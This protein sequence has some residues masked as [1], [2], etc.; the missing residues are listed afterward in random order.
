MSVGARIL[1]KLGGTEWL[2]VQIIGAVWTIFTLYEL[3][4][5][6]SVA[7]ANM[8]A[9]LVLLGALLVAQFVQRYW[10]ERPE[11]DPAH[12]A[13]IKHARSTCVANV[14]GAQQSGLINL[15][16][17]RAASLARHFKRE[18][19]AEQVTT[20]AEARQVNDRSA[21]LQVDA[22]FALATRR[23]ENGTLDVPPPP[24]D[25]EESPWGRLHWNGYEVSS[26]KPHIIIVDQDPSVTEQRKETSEAFVAAVTAMPEGR[27]YQELLTARRGRSV[28][29]AQ[30]IEATLRSD[31]KHQRHCD[32]C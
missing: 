8:I 7:R 2:A 21:F 28:L 13:A 19:C 3:A 10:R 12:L 32:D 5:N 16:P 23:A 11:S 1:G 22:A 27:E 17:H 14:P 18:N 20:E 24:F 26:G 4:R 29:R 15:P 31:R 30:E 9:L 25:W 6:R